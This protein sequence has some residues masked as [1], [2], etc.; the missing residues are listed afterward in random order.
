MTKRGLIVASSIGLA[1]T[2]VSALLLSRA[3]ASQPIDL[4]VLVLD[5][6][7]AGVAGRVILGP[8]RVHRYF[9]LGLVVLSAI[10]ATILTSAATNYLIGLNVR[11]GRPNYA[12]TGTAVATAIIGFV[13]YLVAATVYGFAGTRQGVRV[14]SR[15]GLLLLLLLAVLP[16]LNVLGL[17]GVTVSAFV[18]RSITV[19][20][21]SADGSAEAQ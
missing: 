17:I 10:A 6:I 20:K 15:V 16:V 7:A 3:A 1:A 12:P 13:V 9:S 21:P 8:V 14:G 4:I 2:V 19:A 5:I 18:R 11:F